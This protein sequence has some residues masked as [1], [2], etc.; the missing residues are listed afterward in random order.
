MTP[1]WCVTFS[2]RQFNLYTAAADRHCKSVIVFRCRSD[3][4][5]GN[6]CTEII[7]DF[8]RIYCNHYTHQMVFCLSLH[9]S[10]DNYDTN[11][12]RQINTLYSKSL[13]KFV[14]E[15]DRKKANI[16]TRYYQD[17]EETCCFHC[18]DKNVCLE[19]NFEQRAPQTNLR[20]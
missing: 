6:A 13:S 7:P 18:Q 15:F 2:I 9:Y 5:N 11:C 19:A 16:K 14:S 12:L 10:Y 4:I 1:S 8:I 3:I 20:L 17:F